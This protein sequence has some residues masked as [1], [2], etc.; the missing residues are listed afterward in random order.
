[1]S[2]M[3]RNIARM[4]HSFTS[5]AKPTD[6]PD[7]KRHDTV[8]LVAVE[9]GIGTTHTDKEIADMVRD[10][11]LKDGWELG[12]VAKVDQVTITREKQVFGTPLGQ[13]FNGSRLAQYW[14]PKLITFS[15]IY[16]PTKSTGHHRLIH[17]LSR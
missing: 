7:V 17:H 12:D 3:I 2:N 1:M 8:A 6:Y 14:H 5:P 16:W 15:T 9:V 13:S 11:L 10:S 4:I